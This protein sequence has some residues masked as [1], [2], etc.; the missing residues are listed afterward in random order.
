MTKNKQSHQ[1]S[2]QQLQKQI[3]DLENRFKRALADYQNLEK[4]QAS[5][6]QDFIK[7][8]NES[9]LDKLLP[10]I[11]D[12]ERA[13]NHLNDSGLSMILNQ[14]LQ[15]LSSEGIAPIK[16]DNQPF[17]P[18]SMDCVEVVPGKKDHVINTVTKGYLYHDRILRPA[19]VEVGSG[20]SSK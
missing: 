4:R 17:D 14:F 7:F 16:T 11:D 2:T 9:L 18:K 5:Q 10:L 6:K 19:R 20:Q 13:Q 15:I 8:A 12:L 1:P 3:E